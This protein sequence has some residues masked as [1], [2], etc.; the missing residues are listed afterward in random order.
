[1]SAIV[2]EIQ[3]ELLNQI[4]SVIP[5]SYIRLKHVID[6]TQNTFRGN[7]ERYGVAP[8]ES[9]PA[10]GTTCHVTKDQSFK[11]ALTN[12]YA[13][14]RQND[15][16]QVDKSLDLYTVMDTLE[17]HLLK[18]RGGAA[19]ITLSEVINVFEFPTPAPTYLEEDKVV[20]LETTVTVRYRKR[21]D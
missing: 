15:D 21:I 18:V 5:S 17:R 13:A 9:F 19:N 1:M 20:V 16:V 7:N 3:D 6:P 10:P 14:N 8:L 4:E 2:R 11:L 12:G